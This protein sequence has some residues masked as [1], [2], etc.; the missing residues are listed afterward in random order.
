VSDTITTAAE[1]RAWYAQHLAGS[2]SISCHGRDVTIVFE[3]DAT[4]VY[5]VACSDPASLRPDE[6]VERIIPCGKGRTRVEVRKFAV[7]RARLMRFIVPAVAKFTVSTPEAGGRSG[8]EKRVLYGPSLPFDFDRLRVVLRPG[9]GVAWTCV[10]AY[11][12]TADE[13]LA[14]RRLKRA[15]FP[16]T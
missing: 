10:S 6:R 5:S 4:H 8:N 12:V 11:P 3:R 2:H 14:A 7:E 16:P 1:A 13:W 15:K 9:P